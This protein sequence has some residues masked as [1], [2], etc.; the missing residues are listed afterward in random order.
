MENIYTILSSIRKSFSFL[1]DDY[2]LKLIE[3]VPKSKY[4]DSG[5]YAQLENNWCI[6]TFQSESGY[7]ENIGVASKDDISVGEFV[8]RWAFLSTKEKMTRLQQPYTVENVFKHFSEFATP[9]L[10]EMLELLQ[11]P[12]AFKDRLKELGVA[13]DST[14]ITIEMIRA[15]RA[16]LHSLGLDSSLG[17]AMA[18]LQ[19]GDK[20]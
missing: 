10:R 20:K 3:L 14:L 1:W 15:E 13:A 16:R 5:Y 12:M 2:G 6:V 9:Y 17:A 7:W 19:K 18:N 11:N 4:H 8:D